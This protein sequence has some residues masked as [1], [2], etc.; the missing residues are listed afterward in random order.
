MVQATLPMTARPTAPPTCW[1]ALNMLEAIPECSSEIPATRAMVSG[2]KISPAVPANTSMGRHTPRL[3]GARLGEHERGERDRGAGQG[4]DGGGVGP[5]RDAVGAG[6]SVRSDPVCA[7]TLPDGSRHLPFW[8]KEKTFGG[9]G[10]QLGYGLGRLPSLPDRGALLGEGAGSLPGVGG[11]EDGRLQ[12]GGLVPALVGGP[13]GGAVGD[14][15][16]GDDG[17]RAVG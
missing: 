11:G 12:G 6:R 3:L 10:R 9:A 4:G 17:Q 13:V 1:P 7:R 14:L 16:S 5:V 8:I 2:T 15:L